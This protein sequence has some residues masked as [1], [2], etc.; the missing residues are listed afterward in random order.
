MSTIVNRIETIFDSTTTGLARGF[1]TA[2]TKG[3]D[4]NREQGVLQKG[5]GAL[6]LQSVNTGT[7]LKAGLAGGAIYAGA[8]VVDFAR[9]SVDAFVGLAGDVRDFQ[10][11]SGASAEDASRFV[12]VL[13][14]MEIASDKGANAIFRLGRNAVENTARL[15]ANGVEIARNAD[16]STNLTETLLNVADAYTKSGDQGERNALVMAA[17]GRAGKDLIPVLEQGREGLKKFFE[18]A[19]DGHQILSQ[20]DVDRAREYELAMDALGDTAGGFQRSLG[21]ALVP[22]I[23][24]FTEGLTSGL[25]IVDDVTEAAGGLP[26]VF[27]AVVNTISPLDNAMHGVS[28]ASKLLEGD[29]GGAAESMVRT[30]PVIGDLAGMFGVGGQEAS[31]YA[32]QTERLKAAQMEYANA[33]AESGPKSREAAAARRELEAAERPVADV[34]REIAKGLQDEWQARAQ[35]VQGVLAEQQA[36]LAAQDANVAARDALA[37]HVFLLGTGAASADQLAAAENDASQGVLAAANAAATAAVSGLGPLA[38]EQEKA[39]AGASAAA[40]TYRFF[41]ATLAPGDPLRRNLMNTAAELDVLGAKKP[42]P[43]VNLRIDQARQD[44]DWLEQRIT[45]LDG[46]RVSISVGI[47][48]GG[49]PFVRKILQERG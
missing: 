25:N 44:L 11:A 29:V 32:Q 31:A 34:Q 13:D 9:Q 18:G 27:G 23:T 24:Q 48:D 20:E 22:T 16:G 33:V 3:A 26:G 7:L 1:D 6:G 5:L 19:E 40:D 4:L 45:G 46:R 17:F 38:G 8:K 35:I 2:R 39:R 14:D 30:L 47:D 43:E 42:K 21:G 15:E 49:D 12:A 10:R 36:K 41:A 37:E 28:A